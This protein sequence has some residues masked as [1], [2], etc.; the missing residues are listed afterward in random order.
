MSAHVEK[1]KTL[2]CPLS[3]HSVPCPASPLLKPVPALH[4]WELPRRHP[5]MDLRP[6][7]VLR[8]NCKHTTSISTSQLLLFR[9]VIWQPAHIC[10][11]GVKQEGGHGWKGLHRVGCVKAA[12]LFLFLSLHT[13]IHTLRSTSPPLRPHIFILTSPCRPSP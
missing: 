1:G 7:L 12:L 8:L 9:A 11:L 10:T 13:G 2:T 5:L 4:P 6:L 3:G